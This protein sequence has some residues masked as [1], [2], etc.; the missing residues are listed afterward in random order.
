ML[1]EVFDG[2]GDLQKVEA[3]VL[4]ENAAQRYQES[5]QEYGVEISNEEALQEMVEMARIRAPLLS[6][7]D[8]PTYHQVEMSHRGWYGG[9]F[10]ENEGCYVFMSQKCFVGSRIQRKVWADSLTEAVKSL[11][12]PRG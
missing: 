12:K 11:K 2:N 1:I 3:A 8:L 6:S 5:A 7:F 10:D 4:C 9:A